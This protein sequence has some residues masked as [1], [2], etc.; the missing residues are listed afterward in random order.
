MTDKETVLAIFAH[1]DDELTTVG[2]L[3]NHSQR[4]DRT[5]L[6]WMTY[7]EEATTIKGSHK[8]KARIREQHSKKVGALLG[9]ETRILG[10]RDSHVPRTVESAF[11]V[12][13]LIREVKPT[14][15]ITWGI[16]W[17]PGAGHPNHRNTAYNVLDAISYARFPLEGSKFTPHRERVGI[18]TI[19]TPESP[20]PV[21]YVNIDEHEETL[22]KFIDIYCELYGDWQVE[23]F[24][25]AL[26]RRNG[27]EAGCNLAEAYNVIQT[28]CGPSKYLL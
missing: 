2:T 23:Q 24:G 4:G 13:D 14:I 1:P 8:E 10:F 6:A 22:R 27:I 15:I 11:V 9:V 28:R 16:S 26:A 20:F 25:L 3:A 12:A 5:L 18:Y 7:G 19:H 21:Q 17:Q